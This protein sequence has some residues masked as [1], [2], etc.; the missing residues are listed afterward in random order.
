MA[1]GILGEAALLPRHLL[2]TLS[3]KY[4]EGFA[5]ET[6]CVTFAF[7]ARGFEGDVAMTTPSAAT[8]SPAQLQALGGT[9]LLGVFKTNPLN[10]VR[11]NMLEVFARTGRQR[12]QIIP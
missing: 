9:A 5:A 8:D 11:P 1:H 4:P 12:A 2:Q 7:Q 6:Q 3:L 10:R